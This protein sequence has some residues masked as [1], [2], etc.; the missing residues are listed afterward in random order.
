LIFGLGRGRLQIEERQTMSRYYR[1]QP[2]GLEISG[3]RSQTSLDETPYGID[4][5][6]GP[7]DVI[8]SDSWIARTATDEVLIIEA[9]GHW[10]NGDVEGVRI[11]PETAT[12]VR[13]IP[14]GDW[15]TWLT[16]QTQVAEQIVSRAVDAAGQAGGL[17]EVLAIAAKGAGDMTFSDEDLQILIAHY[18]TAAAA[19]YAIHL[20]AKRRITAFEVAS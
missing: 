4:A 20:E 17:D 15:L 13:R 14:V 1:I 2:T 8:G 12:I 19:L 11:D 3:H 7:N 6:T 18:G 5:F 16:E 9:E 10:D